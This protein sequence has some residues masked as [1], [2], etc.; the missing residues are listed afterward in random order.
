MNAAINGS[1][2]LL[3]VSLLGFFCAAEWH[4]LAPAVLQSGTSSVV[5]T[6]T[7][8]GGSLAAFTKTERE[9]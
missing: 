8:G 3:V 7:E 1:A 5:H 2:D 4:L 9:A 6:R